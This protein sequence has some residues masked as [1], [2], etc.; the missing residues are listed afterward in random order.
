MSPGTRGDGVL[1]GKEAMSGSGIGRSK[2]DAFNMAVEW[3][4]SLK[5]T[6]LC[7]WHR[8][9][10]QTWPSYGRIDQITGRPP[11]RKAH[12]SGAIQEFLPAAAAGSL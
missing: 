10:A 7:H 2:L 1:G 11:Q 5:H 3:A 6:R 12:R 8:H 4:P 9:P